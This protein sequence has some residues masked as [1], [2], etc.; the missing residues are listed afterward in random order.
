MQEKEE[1]EYESKEIGK[2]TKA[3]QDGNSDPIYNLGRDWELISPV[4][5]EDP[6]RDFTQKMSIKKRAGL[7]EGFLHVLCALTLFLASLT[8]LD[9]QFFD[10]SHQDMWTNG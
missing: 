6:G 4:S 3:D 5:S 10:S 2:K 9:I 7:S 8:L 1:M